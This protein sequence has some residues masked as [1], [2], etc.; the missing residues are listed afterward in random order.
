MFKV[1][2]YEAKTLSWWADQRRLIDFDPPYQRRGGLWSKSDKEFLIDSILNEYDIPKFYLADFSYGPSELNPH[3][4]QFAVIDG[5]QRFEAILDFFDG[6]ITLARDFVLTDDRALELGRLGY[7]DLKANLP[8]I[9]SRFENFN[10][11]VMTV[12]T[13]EEGKINELFVRLNRNKTLTGP[14]IRNAMQG[15][16]PEML[17]TIASDEFFTNRISFAVHRGQDLDIA[18]K[19]L[20]VESRGEIA[21]TKRANLDRM[22]ESG[23]RADA[24]VDIFKRATDRVLAELATID[25][26]FLEKDYLL[27]RQG[28]LVPYYWFIRSTP[29]SRYQHVRPFLVAFDE[30]VVTNR[31]LGKLA[32]T[33]KLVDAELSRYERLNRSINDVGSIEGR[34]RILTG[35]FAE[36]LK[37]DSVP[38]RPS[39]DSAD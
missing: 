8:A 35:R 25:A 10:L 26:I 39:D 12:I 18:A 38:V 30:A 15:P 19:F 22:V 27:G 21:E 20:I 9:A 23:Y 33:T 29:P 16:I 5:K 17:R 31:E 6:R 4:R 32:R 36:Y 28:P 14:E 34:V 3:N 1:R 2:Q 13:D 11:T 24:D 7:R 37:T